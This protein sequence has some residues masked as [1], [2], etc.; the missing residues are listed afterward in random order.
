MTPTQACGK[1]YIMHPQ[2]EYALKSIDLPRKYWDAE[3]TAYSLQHFRVVPEVQ[4]FIE[5]IDDHLDPSSQHFGGGL[6][7]CGPGAARNAGFLLSVLVKTLGSSK[8]VH[9]NGLWL[10]WLTFVDDAKTM[11][12][13]ETVFYMD[14]VYRPKILVLNSVPAE[15]T[16]YS[17]NLLLKIASRRYG[18]GL[19]TIITTAMRDAQSVAKVFL[20]QIGIEDDAFRVVQIT[21]D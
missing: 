12:R 1:V 18:R 2:S 21:S 8:K 7:L 20:P 5:N 19:P 16:V 13:E 4:S 11:D 3:L 17:W 9:I 6:L 10:D 14:E 15:Q